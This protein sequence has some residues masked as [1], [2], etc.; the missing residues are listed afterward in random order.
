[1][2]IFDPKEGQAAEQAQEIAEQTTQ[3]EATETGEEV[4]AE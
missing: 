4:A 1:M 2:N 3:A